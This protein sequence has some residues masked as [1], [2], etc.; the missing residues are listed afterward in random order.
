MNGSACGPVIV[1]VFK[2]GDRYLAI[3]VVGSTPT[4]FRHLFFHGSLGCF[5]RSITHAIPV[6]ASAGYGIGE[7]CRWKT[8]LEHN[9]RQS[10]RFCA[11]I[12]TATL[13]GLS[14]AYEAA[15]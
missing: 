8:N 6:V 11:A 15:Q 12:P 1:P 4:R 13:I 3:A 10:I 9:P 14:R 5:L 2:T 7:A